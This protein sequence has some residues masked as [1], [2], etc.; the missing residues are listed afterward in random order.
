MLVLVSSAILGKQVLIEL[1]PL[2]WWGQ[3]TGMAGLRDIFCIACLFVMVFE[4]CVLFWGF[5]PCCLLQFYLSLSLLHVC[6]CVWFSV[7]LLCVCCS[8]CCSF[9]SPFLSYMYAFV[10]DSLCSYC[11][12]LLQFYLSL[13]LLHVCLCVWFSVQL[14]CVF[15][16]VFVA[17]LSLPFSPTCMPLCVIL[18]AVI[19]CVCC[20]FISP[21]PTCMLLCVI[22]CAVILCVIIN[23][24]LNLI[25]LN[26]C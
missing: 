22:L 14:L 20:S 17:V 25:Y 9:I 26:C 4:F 16:A 12:C 3:N 24:A 23:C 1:V 13:S 19:V 11:V 21:S 6:V 8:F 2:R 15:V 18:C 10:C 5:I 7:Q